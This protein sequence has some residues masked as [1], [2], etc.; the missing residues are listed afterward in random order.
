MSLVLVTAPQV[1][2]VTLD[3]V[4]THLRIDG[5][6][7]DVF[8]TALVKAARE[9]CESPGLNRALIAQTWDLW[10]DKWPDKDYIVLPRPPL[11]AVNSV[12]YYDTDDAEYTFDSVNYFVDTKSEPSR[13]ALAYNKT[14][15]TTTLRP[16]NGIVVN[17]DAG[18][19]TAD[20]VP[21]TI[22]QAMLLLIGGWYEN[23]ESTIAGTIAREV[24][25]SVKA[26]LSPLRVVPV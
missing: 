14:W 5:T 3:E 15:P 8:L 10:L 11:L 19:G 16:A 2:P 18:Y 7:E 6:D 20:K 26:L 23:R 21:Q 25:F 22:K 4:K 13:I 17:F 12:K 9:Y 24:P 1:E